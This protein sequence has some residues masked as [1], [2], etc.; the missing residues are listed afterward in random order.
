MKK[1]LKNKG[2]CFCKGKQNPKNRIFFPSEREKN[3]SSF[4][5]QK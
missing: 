5:E 4:Y 1:K 3:I 2:K